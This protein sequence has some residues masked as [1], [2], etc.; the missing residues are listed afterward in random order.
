MG[1]GAM[2]VML[3]GPLVRVVIGAT[4]LV[5]AA[6][7]V[8]PSA[9]GGQA[10]VEISVKEAELTPAEATAGDYIS[11]RSVDTGCVSGPGMHSELV[12]AVF[13]H[14]DFV[15][16]DQ[17][18]W[19]PGDALAS[20]GAH[21]Q[22]IGGTVGTWSTNFPAPDIDEAPPGGSIG[23]GSPVTSPVLQAYGPLSFTVDGHQLD[24]VA[25]CYEVPTAVG[26]VS[27]SPE[28]P[29]LGSSAVVSSDDPCP[30]PY[31]QGGW[32]DLRLWEAT[33]AGTGLPIIEV[34]ELGPVP[35]AEDGSWSAT[36]DLPDEPEHRFAFVMWC[37]NAEGGV[38][39][40]YAFNPFDVREPVDE[41]DEPD[42]PGEPIVTPPGFWDDVPLPPGIAPVASVASPAQAVRAQPSY[43]G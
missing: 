4:V 33:G 12:W 29:E 35:I 1:V 36:F 14:G 28:V 11:V 26:S 9:V 31:T 19:K 5:S 16:G 37:M 25:K 10:A 30:M 21:P 39:L 6:A 15:W 24:F 27:I 17:L 40:G 2:R 43:S 7:V 22:S 18:G 3:R 34:H 32:V 38:T 41:P 13:P 20:G 8:R 23:P 42:E